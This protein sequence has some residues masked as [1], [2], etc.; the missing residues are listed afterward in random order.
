M[1]NT[2]TE[3]VTKAA[4]VK[5]NWSGRT[6][7]L[8]M[9]KASAWPKAAGAR[10]ND[11][12]LVTAAGLISRTGTA[13]HLALAMMLR[14]GGATQPELIQATGDTAVNA[15]RDAITAGLVAVP[16]TGRNGH[17]AYALA[18]P[19]KKAA[20]PRKAAGKGK[21]KAAKAATPAKAAPATPAVEP[22]EKPTDSA[23]NA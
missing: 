12:Q 4:P 15:Y 22:A 11:G 6:V 14:E 13:K 9:G 18:L 16:V 3:T 5:F 7:P 8:T 2:K 19:V 10:P 21:G 20:A 17:K 1:N 23:P